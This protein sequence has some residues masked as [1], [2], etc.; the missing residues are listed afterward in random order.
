MNIPSIIA[1]GWSHQKAVVASA[2]WADEVYLWVPFTSLRMRQNKLYNFDELKETINQLH[3]QW[4]KAFLTMNIFP[5]N[6]DIQIFESITEKIADCWADSII[7]SDPGTFRIIRKYLPDVPLHLSTQTTTLNSDSVKFWADLWVKRIILARELHISEIEEIKKAVPEIELEAFIHGAMC[8]T[9]SGRCLLWDYLWGRPANKWECNHSC[10]FQ[11][12]VF[13]QE[14]RREWKMLEVTED[15]NGEH[16]FSSRDLCTIDRLG[17]L[18]PILDSMKIEWRS[19]SEFYVAAIVKAYKHVRD[20][21]AQWKSIDENIRNLVDM[22]PHRTYR[23][24]FLFHN[25]QEFPDGEIS[26]EER[27]STT[28]ERVTTTKWT[29]GPLFNRNFFGIFSQET[30]EKDWIIYH[31]IDPKEELRRWMKLNFI[32]P[33]DM[34]ILEITDILDKNWKQIEKWDCNMQD[35][36][37]ATDHKLQGWECLYLPP[38]QIKE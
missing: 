27:K 19:K 23:D 5:R 16:I 34:W 1:P 32:S 29:A 35:V 20:G 31:H 3:Q 13:I 33:D 14:A 25:L 6:K 21:I 12:R 9:Y 10:R 7:F 36:Y 26:P 30:K 37:V 24:G 15:E 22:I 8:M 18:M 38:D 11:Y 17:E 2:Y 28:D 4:T